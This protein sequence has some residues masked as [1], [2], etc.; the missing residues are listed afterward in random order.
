M[1]HPIPLEPTIEA[2][3]DTALGRR[4]ADLRLVNA[5]VADVFSGEFI[6]HADVLVSDGLIADVVPA[7]SGEA[8]QT[9][10]LEGCILSP[11]L[12]DSHVHIESSML[13]PERF[14]ELVA[15]HG[16]AAVVADPHEIA[17]V[18]GAGGIRYMH[19][20]SKDLPVEFFF[21]LPSCVPATPFEHA[22]AVLE[23]EDLEMFYDFPRVV[24]L[25]EVMNIPGVL[26]R[27]PML[28]MK[29]R[30]GRVRGF[31]VDGHT[32]GV[33]GAALSACAAAGLESTHEA[34]TKEEM[35]DAIRRGLVVMIR[36][37]S[38]AK[39]LPELIRWVTPQNAERCL[40][41]CD[42]ANPDDIAREGHMERHLRLAVAAGVAPITA[43]R[44]ATINAARHFGLHMLGAVAP[45]RRADLVVFEDLV[46]FRV[47]KVFREGRLIAEDG[48]LLSPVRAPQPPEAVLSC[49]RSAPLTAE[50]FAIP[51]PSG[52]ARVIEL[53]PHEILTT[54]RIAEVPT[55]DGFADLS[56]T[57]GL[58]KVAVVERHHGLGTVGLGL[59]SGYIRPDAKMP[60]AVAATIA[61]D[62]HN[63]VVA[64]GTDQDMLAAVERLRAIGGGMVAVKDGRVADELPL[65]VAGLMTTEP[66]E[67]VARRLASLYKTAREA[68][69]I[70]DSVEPVMTL[71]FL[72]L[73][74][75]NDLR[76]TD[77]GLFDVRRF[78]FTSVDPG[79]AR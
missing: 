59:L 36:Q 63:I 78:A 11:G 71:A 39:N 15:P 10:D 57:T 21:T 5:L 27:D 48:K 1:S 73:P 4:P 67:E 17:N 24:G 34:S 62:S 68:F 23:S 49:V 18:L 51:L 42:D 35:H 53:V 54:E 52:R 50:S 33:T 70:E 72:A 75:I 41:C 28:A 76:V 22:G 44:M 16:T 30:A 40:F 13:V 2:L 31:R 66:A 69:A 61:H 8:L 29:I 55:T 38:A 65:P 9:I 25:G 77:I 20:A 74:V 56:R 58:V 43:I 45:G 60:G 6:E 3:V 12:I 46:D 26:S 47:R 79:V 19:S 14:A 37:G 7:G 32:P 64:G